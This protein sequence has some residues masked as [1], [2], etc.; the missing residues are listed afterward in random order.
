VGF[1]SASS[2]RTGILLEHYRSYNQ[3]M[4]CKLN[5]NR[6]SALMKIL[7]LEHLDVMKRI[8][9]KTA[10]IYVQENHDFGQLKTLSISLIMH[11]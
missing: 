9:A 10:C 2:S 1:I 4:Y 7:F 3:I 11:R 8:G 6:I 5:I